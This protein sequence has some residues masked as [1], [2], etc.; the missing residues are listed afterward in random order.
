MKNKANSL[1]PLVR[2]EE[3]IVAQTKSTYKCIRNN[4][5]KKKKTLKLTTEKLHLNITSSKNKHN[6]P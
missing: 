3:K 6:Q 1:I 2:Y 4:L 5:E